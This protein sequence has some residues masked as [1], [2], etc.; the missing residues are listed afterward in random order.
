MKYLALGD[1]FIDLTY[2]GC[3]TSGLLAK[4]AIA[5]KTADVITVT[6]G[7]NDLLS[8]FFFK[9]AG[10]RGAK[11]ALGILLGNLDE[12]AKRLAAYGCPVIL[13]TIYDPTDGDDTRAIEL[14]LPIEARQALDLIN[15][16]LK[17]IAEH[18]G[19][20]LCDL[21]PL[22]H[23]HGNWPLD[24]GSHRTQLQRR[25]ANRKRMEAIATISVAAGWFLPARS[26]SK[27]DIRYIRL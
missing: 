11:V 20:L 1:S 18:E 4:F 24:R 7:G 21:E 23:G 17:Q 9:M 2:D 16:R 25:D 6:I 12:I 15:G 26:V 10:D 22:F 5:P 8:G 19:F 14:G 27:G 3:V 13:N